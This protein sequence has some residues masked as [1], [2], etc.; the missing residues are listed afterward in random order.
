MHK[1]NLKFL[2]LIVFI[3]CIG[4]NNETES[5]K[6]ERTVEKDT[7]TPKCDK[8]LL[9][10]CIEINPV[11]ADYYKKNIADFSNDSGFVCS[12]GKIEN[13]MTGSVYGDFSKEFNVNHLP[14]LINSPDHSKYI[15]LDSYQLCFKKDEK[16]N[17]YCGGGEV[18]QEIDLADRKNKT[19]KRIAFYGPG[20]FIEDAKWID[21]NLFV[22]YG[23]S[24]KKLMIEVMDISKKKYQLFE[25]KNELKTESFFMME[26]RL[27]RVNF[28]TIP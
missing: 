10:K 2:I 5:T 3:F 16:G 11:W 7:S 6:I 23:M 18:D 24:D 17:L 25:S 21:N 19:V 14:F 15:D 1:N 20:C 26:V 13:I 4:C 22:L 27:K 12:K 28:D 8:I 9:Q